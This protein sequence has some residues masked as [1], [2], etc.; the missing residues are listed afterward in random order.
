MSTI[1]IKFDTKGKVSAFGSDLVNRLAHDIIFQIMIL[2]FSIWMFFWPVYFATR[3]NINV[4]VCEFGM[5]LTEKAFCKNNA[6]LVKYNVERY[7]ID[8]LYK[9]N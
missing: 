3:L 6:E 7:Y 1:E 8:F 9:E 2:V 5:V 4:F